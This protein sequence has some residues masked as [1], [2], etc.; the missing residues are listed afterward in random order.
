MRTI[1]LRFKRILNNVTSI[2]NYGLNIIK[3]TLLDVF[4]PQVYIF[5]ECMQKKCYPD[6]I[7]NGLLIKE[8]MKQNA[9]L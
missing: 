1:K 3:R 2:G 6:K 9:H 4:E 7:L 8:L 5:S